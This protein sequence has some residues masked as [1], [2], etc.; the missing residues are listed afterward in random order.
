MAYI[1]VNP[2]TLQAN[3]ECVQQRC[4][5]TGANFM[6]VFKEAALRP[7]LLHTLLAGQSHTRLGLCHYPHSQLPL[8]IL[9][10]KHLLYMISNRQMAQ[11]VHHYEVMYQTQG[12]AL[13]RLAEE[14]KRQRRRIKIVLMV[15]S[16]D[17]REGVPA[18][19]LLEQAKIVES[20]SP[21]LELIGIAANYACISTAPP[22][23]ASIERLIRL[24]QDLEHSLS[25][26]LP[27]LSLGGSDI[28]ELAASNPLPPGVTEIRCG[29]AVYL[30]VYPLTGHPVPGTS[31]SAVLLY[32]QVLECFNKNGRLCVVFDFGNN[33]ASP[34]DVRP[35]LPQMHCL[36]ASSGYTIYDI[37]ECPELSI[38]GAEHPF[39]LN[40][41][42]LGRIFSAPRLSVLLEE[43]DA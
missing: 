9:A 34:E 30:G 41:R 27:H 37:T 40:S 11:A 15:E 35:P 29:T 7:E 6:L 31:Q 21:F 8:S 22:S 17:G 38:V 2:L 12:V 5:E 32:S 42:S 23:I 10:E 1:R 33:E 28:L 26:P 25:R 24:K 20:C 3:L 43:S 4:H 14:A 16:G 39:V 36:G 19:S 18:E 13:Q